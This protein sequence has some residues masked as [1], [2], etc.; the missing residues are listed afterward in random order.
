MPATPRNVARIALGAGLCIPPTPASATRQEAAP[1][2]AAHE[3]EKASPQVLNH[4]VIDIDGK[5]RKL[6]DFRGDVVLIVNVAS[7][8]GLTPQYEGLERL[9]RAHRK[10]GF[11]V[12]AFPANDFG[13]QEPGTNE[14]IRAF[15]TERYEVTFPLFSKISVKGED[16][17]PLYRQLARQPEPIGGD[18][19]WNF[20]KFLV[21]RN[22][23]VVARFEPRTAPEDPKLRE[24]LRELLAEERPAPPQTGLEPP[25]QDPRS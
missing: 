15:C 25:P 9:Y 4:T 12:L 23:E 24:R 13:A 21:N 11:T 2:A 8:C 19:A 7:R 6:S 1:P 20:T 14:E 18:P 22:G 17:H 10:E 3:Q 5:P 16:Q